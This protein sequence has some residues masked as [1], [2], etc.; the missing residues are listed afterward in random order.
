[1]SISNAQKHEL[2]LKFNQ[3]REMLADA[4][5]QDKVAR[6]TAESQSSS[7]KEKP[8][9]E[10]TK[11]YKQLGA[12][13][14]NNKDIRKQLQEEVDAY[15]DN[16]LSTSL[17][18]NITAGYSMSKYNQIGTMKSTFQ[19]K[20]EE[21]VDKIYFRQKDEINQYAESW[22]KSKAILTN[23]QMAPKGDPSQQPK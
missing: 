14:H 15:T 19:G 23:K 6:K 3:E 12:H 10:Y 7:K 20:V 1:M 9:G 11:L 2:L 22:V 16:Q 21:P 5:K 4:Y 8:T 18:Q 17:Q 13:H